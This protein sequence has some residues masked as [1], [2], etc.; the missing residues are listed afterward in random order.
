MNRVGEL[1]VCLP[2]DDG[3]TFCDIAREIAREG[4]DPAADVATK[5]AQLLVSH[6]Y[7]CRKRGGGGG[8]VCSRKMLTVLE[9]EEGVVC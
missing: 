8:A 4:L 1:Y 9:E 5:V 6:D 7:C 2:F 3:K